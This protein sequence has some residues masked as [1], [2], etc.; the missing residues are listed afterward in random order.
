MLPGS[1]SAVAPPWYRSVGRAEWKTLFAAQSGWMLDGMDVMLYAFALTAIQ[2]EFHISA[3][4]AGLLASITLFT[5]AFGGALAGFFAD[6]YGRARMLMVSILLYSVFTGVTATSRTFVEL[7]VW[8]AL[9]GF[10]LGA[11]WSAGSVL[12]AETWPA[13]HRGK[14]IGLMQSGWAIGYIFAA[15]LAAVLLPRYGWRPLFMA[16]AVPALLAWCIRREI[17]EP[18]I[19]RHAAHRSQTP[20]IGLLVKPPLFHRALFAALLAT[21]L[22]FAYWGLFTWLPAYLSSPVSKGGVGLGL[23]KSTAWIIPVQVGAFLGYTLFG[24]LA[25]RFGRRPVF[26][27]FVLGAAAVVPVYG[28]AGRYATT[29]LILGPLI[30]FFGHG[31]FSV[32]GALLAE[33]FPSAIRAT[34]QGLCYNFGR[35]VS[36]LAPLSIGAISEHFGIG[37]ALVFTAAFFLAGGVLILFLPETK[38]ESLE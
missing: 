21:S 4:R 9:V 26:L 37:G 15:L 38:G 11:E 29:L 6:R 19:W 23:V 31:Y 36:A 35:G 17:P 34:A 2:N 28:L 24:V 12:V 14:A 1:V 25:D 22:Q 8:R 13:E 33:L 27:L 20:P 3:A 32:F 30:G 5:S 10:G 7:G 16:G 18:E